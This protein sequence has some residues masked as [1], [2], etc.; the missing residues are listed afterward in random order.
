MSLISLACKQSLLA[1]LLWYT[2]FHFL[3]NFLFP[4]SW[5]LT[6]VCRTPNFKK[7]S[8]KVF[9]A[10][11]ASYASGSLMTVTCKS[12]ALINASRLHFGQY[13]GKFVNSVSD[14]ILMRVLLP[15]IGQHTH[16]INRFT[17]YLLLKR[18]ALS[19]M[20]ANL[21]TDFLDFLS[22]QM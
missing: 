21:F 8:R 11:S 14:R 15:H 17:L 7:R 4:L 9:R 12:F 13:S 20:F 19:V 1:G 5:G 16:S 6:F 3:K 18:I 22:G 10:Y 2:L